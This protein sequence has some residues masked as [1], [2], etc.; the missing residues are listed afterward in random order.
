MTKN[1]GCFGAAIDLLADSFP[2]LIVCNCGLCGEL[3]QAAYQ[4]GPLA[5]IA[6]RIHSGERNIPLCLDCVGHAVKQIDA[7]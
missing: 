4:R 1:S 7:A 6:A 3:L 5:V 2:D